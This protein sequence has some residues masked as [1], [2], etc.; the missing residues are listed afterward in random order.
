MTTA[1][2]T[3]LLGLIAGYDRR[4]TGA[5]D[6]LAWVAAAHAGGWT[7]D[8]AQRAVV[9]HYT[10][11]TDW[12]MPAHITRRIAQ[13]RHRVLAAFQLPSHPPELADNG[14]EFIAWARR[15]KAEHLAKGL[16]RWASHGHLPPPLELEA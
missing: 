9:E 14:P 12:L 1:E 5:C 8:L 11:T 4:T 13:A 7:V 6:D 2:V 16:A 3:K 15:R 10:H